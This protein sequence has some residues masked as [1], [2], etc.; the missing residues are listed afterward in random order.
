MKIKVGIS[1]RHIHLT[2]EDYITLFNTNL[3]LEKRNDLSQPNEYASV[4]TVTI[5]GPKG[6][7]E[8]VRVLGPFRNYTQ[9]EVS[10]TDCY[11]LGI[12]APV[13]ESG[14]L[15]DAAEIII[16]NNGRSIKRKAAIIANRHIHTNPNDLKK[17]NLNPLHQYKIK[18]NNEKGGILENINLKVSENYKTELHLDTDDA[19]AFLIEQG[20]EVEIIE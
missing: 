12:N 8:N 17:Y 6:S 20:D 14:N 2:K 9:V 7:I 1:N 19:N 4:K 5:K 10:K 3:E 15:S 18:I 16:E 13:R 11:K